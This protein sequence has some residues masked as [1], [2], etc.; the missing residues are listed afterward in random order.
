M[1]QYLLTKGF[2]AKGADAKGYTCL[3]LAKQRNI[4]WLED[5]LS[6]KAKAGDPPTHMRKT[7]GIVAV[8]QGAMLLAIL[9]TSYWL[10]WWLAVPLIFV[11]LGLS[12]FAFRQQGHSHAHGGHSHGASKN[13]SQ[14]HPSKRS[15]VMA[16]NVSL[17]KIETIE[18]STRSKKIKDK[19]SVVLSTLLRPQAESIMGI[20]IAWVGLFTLLYIVLW[21]DSDYKDFRDSHTVYLAFVGG[22][23]IVFIIVWARL[24]FFCPSDPGTITTYEQDVK[25][26][27]DMA[28]RCETPDMTKFCCTCLVKKPIRSKHCAKCGICIARH[29]HHCAWINRC[30]GYGNH[31]LFLAFLLVHCIALGAYAVLVILVLSDATHD[32]HAA[33]VKSDGSANSDNLSAMDVW[34]EIPSLLKNHLLVFMVLVWDVMAIVAI[35]MMLIQ[36]VN[37]IEKNLTINEQMNWR[38]YD[39]LTPKR[40]SRS[41]TAPM[42]MVNPF[43]RGVTWNLKEF[44]CHSG[45]SAVNYRSVFVVPG[46]GSNVS[47]PFTSANYDYVEEKHTA[48]D[49]V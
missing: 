49:V 28:S 29:D 35:V 16:K 43:D 47:S 36:H 22:V 37:N 10:V 26:M 46:S 19:T 18:M 41:T 1:V 17:E 15:M 20:W 31:R 30:V 45:S 32:L 2:D 42:K 34:I 6:G 40:A 33:R 9:A 14:S 38:R 21:V 27:L 8:L 12:L 39:Y 13:G 48:G 3:D 7:R 5:L 11:I 44:F 24:A 4:V 25:V 23:V